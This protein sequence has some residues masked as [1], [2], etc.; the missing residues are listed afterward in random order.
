MIV[1]FDLDGVIIDTESYY[2]EFWDKVGLKYLGT[3]NFAASVKGQAISWIINHFEPFKQAE[4]EIDA[5]LEKMDSSI[6]YEYIPGADVFIRRLKEEGIRFGIVTSSNDKKMAN[7]G[8]VRPELWELADVILTS[9]NFSRTKPD[10]E[11]FLM[12]MEKLGATPEE[13]V[14]FEDSIHGLN[15]ARA[16]GARV[17]GLATSNPRELIEPLS[18]MVI[19]NFVGFSL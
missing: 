2:T 7:L 19:D 18:D 15:A 17:I 1:L 8:K 3:E 10:P 6:P 5:E 13:T 11:C 14:I 12:G 16:A 9:N 4:H